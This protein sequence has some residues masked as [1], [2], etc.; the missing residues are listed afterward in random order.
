MFEPGE[1]VLAKFPFSSLE[2]SK[3]RPCLVLAKADSPEDFIVAF[4]TSSSL[5]PHFKFSVKISPQ[6]KD[7]LQT[8]LKVESYI[9]IDKVATLHENLLSGSIGKI[10]IPIQREI[11]AKIKMLFSL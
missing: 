4:I 7:F 1:I 2:S 6:E 9:R 10:S 5:P 3:R 11:T 8:G